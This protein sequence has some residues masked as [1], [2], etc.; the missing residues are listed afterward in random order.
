MKSIQAMFPMITYNLAHLC[1][2][3]YYDDEY[4]RADENPPGHFFLL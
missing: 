1:P 2:F 4:L 3:W